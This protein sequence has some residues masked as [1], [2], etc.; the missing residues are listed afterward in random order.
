M[1]FDGTEMKSKSDHSSDDKVKLFCE[2]IMFIK[3]EW[4]A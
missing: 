3:E 1:K 4:F 2:N